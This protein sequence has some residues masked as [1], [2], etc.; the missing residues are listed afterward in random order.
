[1]LIVGMH[2]SSNNEFIGNIGSCS[3]LEYRARISHCGPSWVPR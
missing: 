2:G 1:M 3:D